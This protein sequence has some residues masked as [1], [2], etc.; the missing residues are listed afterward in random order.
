[1]Q[2]RSIA[3]GHDDPRDAYVGSRPACMG[4]LE[5]VETPRYDRSKLKAGNVLRGPSIVDSF[6]STCVIL[7]GHVAAVG[8]LG[9]LVI[10]TR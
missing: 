8:A 2:F 1:M 7:P 9:E 10:R 3:T 6:D 4:S 5:R